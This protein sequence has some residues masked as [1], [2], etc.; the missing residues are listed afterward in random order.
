M[1]SSSE[2]TGRKPITF[3]FQ[4][5]WESILLNYTIISASIFL[6]PKKEHRNVQINKLMRWTVHLLSIVQIRTASPCH[7]RQTY[8]PLCSIQ[9]WSRFSL[10]RCLAL[11]Q[12]EYV[13]CCPEPPFQTGVGSVPWLSA[14][15]RF[16]KPAQHTS[17]LSIISTPFTFENGG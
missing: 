6:L 9:L 4:I 8:K 1:Q 2:G 14:I 5:V 3:F 13:V 16:K 7:L 17:G 12:A 11:S 15:H 10:E